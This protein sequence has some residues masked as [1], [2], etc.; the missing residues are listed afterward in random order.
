MLTTTR[1]I[2]LELS[3]S[4]AYANTCERRAYINSRRQ[5]ARRR[6]NK[7]KR[8]A[9]LHFG[10][11]FSKE[12]IKRII[13]GP[14]VDFLLF[15][16]PRVAVLSIDLHW[17]GSSWPIPICHFCCRLPTNL[18]PFYAF[19]REEHA[20]QCAR[21]FRFIWPADYIQLG[22]ATQTPLPP[23]NPLGS[24]LKERSFG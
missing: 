9:V 13:I 3:A 11:Y 17:S 16:S 20:T 12:P 21:A 15:I 7:N 18:H 10:V 22:D 6:A 23:L 19:L 14:H 4:I 5:N 2:S 24:V 8:A 1:Q